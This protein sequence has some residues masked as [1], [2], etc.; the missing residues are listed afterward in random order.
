M[1][2]QMHGQCVSHLSFTSTAAKQGDPQ[3]ATSTSSH[4]EGPIPVETLAPAGHDGLSEDS[5][6]NLCSQPLSFWNSQQSLDV[7][8]VPFA[9]G[10]HLTVTLSAHPRLLTAVI[11]MKSRD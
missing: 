8:L 1:I 10:S 2:P 7:S 9:K 4:G 11:C 3:V 5:Q 6:E